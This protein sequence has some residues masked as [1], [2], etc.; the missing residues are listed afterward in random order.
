MQNKKKKTITLDDFDA[1]IISR[2]YTQ[3]ESNALS[4]AIEAYNKKKKRK[5]TA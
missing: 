3:A 2:P 1:F 4:K 5:K